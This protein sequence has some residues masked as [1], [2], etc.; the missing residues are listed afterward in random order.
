MTDDPIARDDFVS[1]I[2]EHAFKSHGQ[3]GLPIMHATKQALLDRVLVP[4]D[5]W[6]QTQ[7]ETPEKLDLARTRADLEHF[8]RVGLEFFPAEY[9]TEEDLDIIISAL[10]IKFRPAQACFFPINGARKHRKYSPPVMSQEIKA[11]DQGVEE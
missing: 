1:N 10:R 6:D 7:R 4:D 9:V 3:Y 5:V 11:P 2:V 8:L